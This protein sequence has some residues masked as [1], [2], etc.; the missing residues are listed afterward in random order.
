MDSSIMLNFTMIL[1]K[2]EFTFRL[3]MGSKNLA[4]YCCNRGS[5][6]GGGCVMSRATYRADNVAKAYITLQTLYTLPALKL[7]L[8]HTYSC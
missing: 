1:Y 2:V 8:F 3:I 6:Y 4:L 5:G 7:K